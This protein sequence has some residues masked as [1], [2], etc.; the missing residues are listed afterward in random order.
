[1]AVT[2]TPTIIRRLKYL[3]G[4]KA[5]ITDLA[6][7]GNYETD[8]FLLTPAMFGLS[9][10]EDVNFSESVTAS[11][12]SGFTPQWVRSTKRVRLLTGATAGAK[13]E[14]FPYVKASI[15]A[16]DDVTTDKVIGD[17]ATLL[18][19]NHSW[20]VASATFTEAT[21]LSIAHQPDVPRNLVYCEYRNAGDTNASVSCDF[22]TVGTFN[23]ATVQETINLPTA[24]FADGDIIYRTGYQPFDSITSI[25]PS[26][27]A[28]A[29]AYE[30]RVGIGSR[31]GLSASLLGP[32]YTDVKLITRSAVPVAISLVTGQTTGTVK[33]T[34]GMQSV[35]F[36]T[37]TANDHC[38]VKYLTGAFAEWDNGVDIGTPTL[39]VTAIGV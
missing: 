22:V 11:A 7:I 12:T 21:P 26:V 38:I 29:A 25:T 1:M 16:A 36:S 19:A 5:V 10:L 20:I 30:V 37:I 33:P 18:G 14:V 17:I 15:N 27:S 28:A 6:L 9:S 2:V 32:A 8:G 31:L 24:T 4:R 39:R 3:G 23:G 34:V 13:T 35:L